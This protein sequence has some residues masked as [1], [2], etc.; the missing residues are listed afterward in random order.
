ME[1]PND[2]G[3]TKDFVLNRLQAANEDISNA[4]TLLDANIRQTD[5]TSRRIRHASDYD[6]FYIATQEEAAN[7]ISTAE[8]F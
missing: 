1:Q 5:C 2:I 3:T 8:N 6:D 7:L 4:K